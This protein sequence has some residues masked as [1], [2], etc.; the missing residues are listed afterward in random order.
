MKKILLLIAMCAM[1]A[2][3]QAQ[4]STYW[5][6]R[7]SLYDTLTIHEDDIVF[8]GNSITDGCEWCELLGMP[9]VRNR[10]ISGDYT[11]GIL[12]RMSQV[13]KGHPAKI[14]MLI[15]INDCSR[16]TP[17]DTI[18]GNIEKIVHRIKAESPKTRI[19]LQSILPVNDCYNMFQG[20]TA[21]YT[22]IPIANEKIRA[23]AERENVTFIDLYS[24]F[25][26]PATGKINPALTNDGLHLLGVGY[27]LWG[28]IVRPYVLE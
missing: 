26:I 10:G 3:A 25:V 4:F 19:Y 8:L 24:R 13:T 14:F 27:K 9:N 5:H 28:E 18:V 15:G 22:E 12:A 17:V 2:M 21:H 16:N 11:L 6:Q 1:C 20:H 7:S 23:L